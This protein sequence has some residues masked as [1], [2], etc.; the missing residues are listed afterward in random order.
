MVEKNNVPIE[1]P[2]RP[3]GSGGSGP[4]EE[5]WKPPSGP[6]PKVVSNVAVV[7]C[8]YKDTDALVVFYAEG[9]VDKEVSC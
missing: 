5:P 9:E 8:N 4:V 7:H 1:E 3:P 6:A 2:F